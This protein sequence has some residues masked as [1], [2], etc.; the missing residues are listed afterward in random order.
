MA[1]T[2]K[3]KEHQRQKLVRKLEVFCLMKIARSR[4][5]LAFS[6]IVGDAHG[7]P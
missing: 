7:I 3:G 1:S 6:G 4:L 2:L 5:G